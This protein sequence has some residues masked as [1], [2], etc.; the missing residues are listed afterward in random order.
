MKNLKYITLV[1]GAALVMSLSSCSDF[2]DKTPDTRVY[3]SN[4]DQLRELLVTGYMSTNYAATCELSS[5]NVIDNNAPDANGN[6]YN[7]TTYSYADDQLFGFEDV[8]MA[9]DNDSP[10]GVWSGCYGAIAVA[11]AVLEKAAEFEEA[12]ADGNGTLSA[13]TRAELNAIKGEA[14]LIRAY[15][16]FILCN[17]FCLPYR[18][19]ELSKQIQG[20]P[21]ITAPETTVKPHYDRGNLADDY[22]KIEADLLEG[23]KY[24]SDEYYDAPKYHFNVAAANAFAARFYLFKREYDKVVT[25]AT[26]AFKGNDPATL[27]QDGWAQTDFY[28][29]SD[30]GRYFTG[31]ARASNMLLISTYSTWWR[32]FM[33]SSR[34]ACNREAR[35]A[36]I[37]GP[38]PSWE[39]CKWVNNSTKET[40]SMHPMFNGVCGTAGGASYGSYFAGNCSEQFEYTDRLAGIGYC[41]EVRSEFNT[42]ETLLCR[43]EAELFLGDTAACFNDIKI[44]D[45]SW[46]KCANASS[47]LV[48][49]TP[50][51][52][53]RFYSNEG[54][55]R[56]GGR[57]FGIMKTIKID[58][59][60]PSDKY[61]L[62]DYMIPWEQCIQH[63]RRIWTVHTGMR[64]FDIKR[65][66][67]SVTHYQGAS[68]TVH[69][70]SWPDNPAHYAIQVPTEV[71]S[72][73][74]D[75][76]SRKP[77]LTTVLDASASVAG[78][79]SNITP[80]GSTGK[81]AK[82]G[83]NAYR[84]KY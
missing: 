21:Y 54:S 62:E 73:G 36:T 81:V 11:N 39:N 69:S 58:Q 9:T 15:H 4:V 10:S 72:A 57:Q 32:R 66:G 47:S 77:T 26:A 48:P 56:T 29:I 84:R 76:T 82:K 6:R 19:P 80:A 31:T 3:L 44:V 33:S 5:D 79:L 65:L 20:V 52:I 1:A 8:D 49:L 41:H 71:L 38:G 7:R 75:S 35:R 34:Y 24:V 17:V 50:Q 46:Q 22:A 37:Q 12:G 23:L 67:L 27:C 74:M 28:Y 25:Y 68:N 43:A 13:D 45:D 60:C 30:I 78:E 42:E 18:G 2:L 14:Y 70:I 55:S 53:L 61:R 51:L 59:V 16:H 63:Y 83:K 40:F 64:F